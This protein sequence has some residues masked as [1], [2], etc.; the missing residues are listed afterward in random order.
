[1]RRGQNEETR[2][3]LKKCDARK[4]SINQ[5][6]TVLVFFFFSNKW[7]VSFFSSDIQSGHTVRAPYQCFAQRLYSSSSSLMSINRLIYY[8]S[9]TAASFPS[10]FPLLSP[11]GW[12]VGRRKFKRRHHICNGCVVED[13]R[14]HHW[15][16]FQLE[17]KGTH[18]F[19]Q[20][21]HQ[22]LSH[23]IDIWFCPWI[24]SSSIYS[25][26]FFF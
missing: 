1:M 22:T 9:D 3:V 17:W 5:H 4:N 14:R 7:Q 21:I 26:R 8:I 16:N 15:K 6:V 12:S 20:P 23:F 19:V 10:Q 24:L 13:V 18:D 25:S 2:E 11:G